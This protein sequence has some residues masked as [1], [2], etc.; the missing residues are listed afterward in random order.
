VTALNIMN[1]YE[2]QQQ[3]LEFTLLPKRERCICLYLGIKTSLGIK[4]LNQCLLLLIQFTFTEILIIG[5]VGL[6]VKYT[7]NE[8]QHQKHQCIYLFFAHLLAT[9]LLL[10]LIG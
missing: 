10:T 1:L 9:L 2:I 4:I 7:Y 3:K 6:A 8:L 5:S